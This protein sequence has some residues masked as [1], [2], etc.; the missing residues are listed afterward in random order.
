MFDEVRSS[1]GINTVLLGI[2]YYDV[3]SYGPYD[4][5]IIYRNLILIN[6]SNVELSSKD[7]FSDYQS[8]HIQSISRSKFFCYACSLLKNS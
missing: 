6:G 1:V 3:K 8:R 4:I 2:P 7:Q 5:V